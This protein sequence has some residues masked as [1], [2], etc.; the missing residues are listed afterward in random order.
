MPDLPGQVRA[1]GDSHVLP[2]HLLSYLVSSRKLSRQVV[3][4]YF[5]LVHP[6]SCLLCLLYYGIGVCC[7]RSSPVTY[8]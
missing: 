2:S 8:E 1:T 5:K 4:R 3:A 7:P 6:V